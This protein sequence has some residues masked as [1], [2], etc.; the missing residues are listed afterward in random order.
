MNGKYYCTQGPYTG[1][2][3]GGCDTPYNHAAWPRLKRPGYEYC[4]C[5]ENCWPDL[6]EHL[7]N[8]RIGVQYLC[9]FYRTPMIKDCGP[10]SDTYCTHRGTC[11]GYDVS[12]P[13]TDLTPAAFM[14]LGANLEQ[15]RIPVDVTVFP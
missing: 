10:D 7:C 2:S 11:T 12:R 9:G 3:C 15:G 6:S 4:D 13:I 14:L 5:R 1:G 8:D